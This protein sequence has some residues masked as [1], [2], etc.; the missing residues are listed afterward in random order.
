MQCSK[1]V[2]SEGGAQAVEIRAPEPSQQQQH[3]HEGGGDE[4]TR[5]PQPADQCRH[6]EESEELRRGEHEQHGRR[7]TVPARGKHA[8]RGRQ[9]VGGQSEPVL[10]DVN[11]AFNEVLGNLGRGG[12]GEINGVP[13][14]ANASGLLYNA[15]L[16]EKYDVAVPQSFDELTEAARTFDAEGITPFYGMLADNWTP[17]SPLAPL[18][19]TVTFTGGGAAAA[20]ASAGTAGPG[21][22]GA[23]ANRTSPSTGRTS[24]SR[25]CI[26]HSLAAQ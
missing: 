11:P 4:K 25:R 9:C 16:F 17:Q 19:P 12:E 6:E 1:P 15:E 21:A 7:G 22:A 10:D 26:E 20:G 23:Q 13:F 5:R 18:R 8:T 3:A 2:L 24:E 14:A